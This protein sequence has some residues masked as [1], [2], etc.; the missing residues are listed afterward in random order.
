MIYAGKASAASALWRQL[1][2]EDQQHVPIPKDYRMNG[3]GC[4]SITQKDDDLGPCRACHG[5][6][7]ANTGNNLDDEN[8]SL[9]G[10]LLIRIVRQ[11]P[12]IRRESGRGDFYIVTP[13]RQSVE[14]HCRSR[15]CSRPRCGGD[16]G[17]D[18]DDC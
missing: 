2:I 4:L 15:W 11:Q 8:P 9:N 12:S 17:D 14:S 7:H 1:S 3:Q 13:S 5:V 18:I 6:S 16:D 10:V